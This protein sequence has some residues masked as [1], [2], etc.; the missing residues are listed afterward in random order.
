MRFQAELNP[1]DAAVLESLMGELDVEGNAVL[2]SNLL[3]MASWAVSERRRGHRIAAVSSQG[4][5]R[6]L[7][8][9]LLERVAPGQDLPR[10]EITW[11]R[12]E[13]E[14]LASLLV[15]E[16]EEPTE[17]LGRLMNRR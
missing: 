14:K 2:L 4:P 17:R 8:M 5:V 10:V 13:L 9:P 1:R 16:P 12:E 15:A 3:A 11:T 6:E 7:V